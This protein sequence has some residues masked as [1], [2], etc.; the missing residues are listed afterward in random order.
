MPSVVK[1]QDLSRKGLFL[2]GQTRHS[3]THFKE[4]KLKI[5][6]VLPPHLI[7]GQRCS[8]NHQI[9]KYEV[10]TQFGNLVILSTDAPN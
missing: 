9:F 1:F 5:L 2:A 6:G 7:G 3:N 10:K 8:L 4:V